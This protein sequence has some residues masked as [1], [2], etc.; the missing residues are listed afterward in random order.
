MSRITKTVVKQIEYINGE[1]FV[2][3]CSIFNVSGVFVT[4][5]SWEDEAEFFSAIGSALDCFNRMTSVMPLD[6]P[7]PLEVLSRIG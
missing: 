6:A 3:A 1:G 7:S 4:E 5:C 2:T